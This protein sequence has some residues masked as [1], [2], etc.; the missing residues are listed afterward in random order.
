MITREYD[1]G[2]Q[3]VLSFIGQAPRADRRIVGAWLQRGYDPLDALTRSGL[4]VGERRHPLQLVSCHPG[5][6]TWR[7]SQRAS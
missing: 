5:R 1:A 7:C 3:A 4:L 2:N 6:F